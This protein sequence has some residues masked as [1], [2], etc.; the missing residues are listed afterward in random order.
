MLR[1]I[2]PPSSAA[3]AAF[4]HAPAW[5]RVAAGGLRCAGITFDGTRA[6]ARASRRRSS[7]GSSGTYAVA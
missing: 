6:T 3:S 7:R 4:P 5:R 1:S 2:G